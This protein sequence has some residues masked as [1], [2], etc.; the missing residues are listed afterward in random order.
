MTNILMFNQSWFARHGWFLGK[1]VFSCLNAGHLVIRDHE[2]A[3][4]CQL[5]SSA[6]EFIDGSNLDVER[7]ILRR[8]QPVAIQ[9]RTN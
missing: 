5:A 4:L 9:V 2:L 1:L 7:F 8:V 3:L 6:I